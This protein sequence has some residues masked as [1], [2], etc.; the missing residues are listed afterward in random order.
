MVTKT[1]V[2][3]TIKT[4]HSIWFETSLSF[5]CD[6]DSLRLGNSIDARPRRCETAKYYG[7]ETETDR[8]WFNMSRPR[9]FR[10]SR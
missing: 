6:P 1:K 2:I 4:N 7:F 5:H 3:E 10:E 8:D 9:L